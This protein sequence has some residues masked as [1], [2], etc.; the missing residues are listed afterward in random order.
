MDFLVNIFFSSAC[1]F[2]I[3]MLS[4]YDNMATMTTQKE[5]KKGK[6]VTRKCIV[7]GKEFSYIYLGGHPRLTCN[8]VKEPGD[9][10]KKQ[11]RSQIANS[12]TTRKRD[13]VEFFAWKEAESK[14]HKRKK[15]YCSECGKL[16]C[17][18]NWRNKCYTCQDGFSSFSDETRLNLDR[19]LPCEV[20]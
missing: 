11:R 6:P 20:K 3:D 15:R 5:V 2:F 9:C 16:L 19:C 7:C 1:V 18:Y 17:S 4:G 13:S 10:W 14:P 8:T 12:K